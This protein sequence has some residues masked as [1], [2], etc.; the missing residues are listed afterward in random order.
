MHSFSWQDATSV[1]E[2]QNATNTTVSKLLGNNGKGKSVIKAG[3]VDLLDLMKEGLVKPDKI[4]NILN[5]PNFKSNS[6]DKN[7]GLRLGAGMTLSEL[8]NNPQ[9]ISDYPALYK[10]IS[11]AATPHIRNRATLGGNLAQRTRCWYFRSKYHD[12]IRKGSGTCF[13]QEGENEFHAIFKNDYCA[14]VHASSLVPSLL[15]YNARVEI[16]GEHDL[17]TE[18]PLADFFIHPKE[19]SN[20]E[21]ILKTGEIITAI[22][23]PVPAKKLKAIYMKQMARESHD[24]PIAEVAVSAE[25]YGDKIKNPMII[26]GSAAPIPMRCDAAEKVLTN[27]PISEALAMRSANAVMEAATPLAKNEYKVYIFKILIKR[28]LLSLLD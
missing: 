14:S 20:T 13:A 21:N 25:V 2:A 19:N 11:V 10:A 7:V 18:I 4:V 24:W 28:A 12:C 16:A 9:I 3:G 17:R 22:I 5:I 23:L 1:K 15:V 8:E 27:Q 26:L 6:Y